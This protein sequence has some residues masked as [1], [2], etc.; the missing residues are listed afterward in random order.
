MS[1]QS[2]LDLNIVLLFEALKFPEARIF[3]TSTHS[4]RA[5]PVSRHTSAFRA[6]LLL[7][8]W[9]RNTRCTLSAARSDASHFRRAKRRNS[10][11]FA[12][13]HI[14]LCA[15]S[16]P[17]SLNRDTGQLKKSEH[18]R[19]MDVPKTSEYAMS[20]TRV[21]SGRWCGRWCRL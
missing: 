4:P 17:A 19:S 6:A 21:G 5:S 7:P 15:S 12:P 16:I 3:L 20:S 1:D 8:M 13:R 11:R 2:K 18:N 14:S 10:L 9:P